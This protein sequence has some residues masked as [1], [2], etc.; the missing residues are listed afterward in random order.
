MTEMVSRSIDLI[1]EKTNLHIQQTFCLCFAVVLDDYST[2]S[3]LGPVYMEVGD[4]RLV[5]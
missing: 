3:Y 2:L 5:R 4:P 1:S